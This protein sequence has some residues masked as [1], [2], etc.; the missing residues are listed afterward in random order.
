MP[1]LRYTFRPGQRIRL[2]DEFS[3]P[4]D[5]R[6]RQPRGPLMMYALP[7]GRP[8]CRLGIS[9]GRKA[10]NAVTRNRIKRLLR[11]AF[12]LAQHDLP[13]GYDLIIVVR[14]HAV[15]PPADYQHLLLDL[16]HS[17]HITWS[18]RQPPK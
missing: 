2:A 6:V 3:R 11:Q 7:T 18:H 14:P 10:G 9:I 13:S 1:H 17:L 15:L 4:F 5:A 16:A 8:H 12:R